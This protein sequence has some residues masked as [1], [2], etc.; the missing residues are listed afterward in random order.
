M[1]RTFVYGFYTRGV[2]VMGI[3]EENKD[4]INFNLYGKIRSV[5]YDFFGGKLILFLSE[6]KIEFCNISKCEI[7]K[8]EELSLDKDVKINVI[9]SKS[10]HKR[11]F[12]KKIDV[13]DVKIDLNNQML[14][15]IWLLTS[16]N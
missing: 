7:I 12:H 4:K 9:I 10:N 2:E 16:G 13:C 1:Q 15:Q 8:K 6:S 5:Q 3:T 14:I 11:V